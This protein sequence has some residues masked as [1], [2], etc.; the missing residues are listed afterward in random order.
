MCKHQLVKLAGTGLLQR[1]ICGSCNAI[2]ENLSKE[3]YY[4][5]DTWA[6]RYDAMEQ[7]GATVESLDQA[8]EW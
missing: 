3:D 6:V 7:Y 4:P 5:L 1:A 8:D 2:L